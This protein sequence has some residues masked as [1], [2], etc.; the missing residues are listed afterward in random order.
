MTAPVEV[1]EC[2]S[3][4]KVPK[5][6]PVSSESEPDTSHMLAD[7]MS[8]QEAQDIVELPL[9]VKVS[10]IMYVK[11]TAH[12]VTDAAT[13][14]VQK[15]VQCQS[16]PALL[17]TWIP[18]NRESGHG[19]I[20][21]F[22]TTSP[23]HVL[24][25][26]MRLASTLRHTR[27]RMR[28]IE[29]VEAGL[30][31]LQGGRSSTSG[32][33]AA[34][35]SSEASRI[36]HEG[37]P[38]SALLDQQARDGVVLLPPRMP[39]SLEEWQRIA[40]YYVEGPQMEL[41]GEKVPFYAES[42]KMFWTPA[43]PKFSVPVSVME[44]ELFAKYESSL[45]EGIGGEEG[46]SDVL[47][48]EVSEAAS[49]VTDDFLMR[50]LSQR[51]FSLPNLSSLEPATSSEKLKVSPVGR[52]ASATELPASKEFM[53]NL[54]TDFQT[55]MKE[56]K[57]LKEQL[58]RP[59]SR[60]SVRH[61]SLPPDTMDERPESPPPPQNV[62]ETLELVLSSSRTLLAH[63][64]MSLAEKARS[65]GKKYIVYPT[66]K[67][68]KLHKKVLDAEKL[69]G[70]HKQLSQPHRKITRSVSLQRLD[71]HA[72]L[73]SA[74][75]KNRR[76]VRKASLPLTLDFPKYAEAHG[77]V[78]A[79]GER[80][81]VRGI[82]N[83]WFDEVFP[84]SR[85][86]SRVKEPEP[87]VQITNASQVELEKKVP[88]RQMRLVDSVTPV[89]LDETTA[90]IQEVEEEVRRLTELIE[91][92]RET[93][94]FH[95]SRRG[96]LY[97]KLGK[98][99]RAL[100]D[101]GRAI[102]MEPQLLDAYWQRHLIYRLQGRNAD[103]L[104]D[105][106]FILKYNKNHAD[107]YL[108]KAEICK[109]QGDSTLAIINYSQALKCQPQNGDIYYS[110]AEMYEHRSELILAMDDYAQSF[111]YN[112]ERTDAMMKHGMHHFDTS[113]WNAAI[114]DFTAL[115]KQ[116]PNDAHARTYRGRAYTKQARYV[117]A[118]KD[119]SAAIH[120]DPMNW[121]AFY[122]RGCLLRRTY[123][124]RAL[125]DF[126]TSVL[127]ND[128]FENLNSF[129][130]RAILYTEL[131]LYS[132][133][134]CDF[135]SVLELDRM[136][137]LAYLNLGLIFLLF[138]DNYFKAIQQ[139]TMALQ[140]TPTY[141]RA[142]LCRAQAYHKI[143]ELPKALKDITRAI[144]LQP[145]ALQMYI[146][147]GQYL[148]EMKKYDLAS[149][150]I[151]YAAVM[152]Q[153]TSPVQRALVQAFSND[154]SK[155]I[156]H[157]SQA[158]KVQPSPAMF[159]LLGKIQMKAKKAKDAVKSFKEALALMNPEG[160]KK[161]LTLDSAEIFYLLGLCYI[162]QVNLLKALDAFTSAIKAS[163]R[164][165]DAFYQRGLCR[166]RLNQ[167]K[168]VED[169]NRA[170]A[171]NPKLFQVYLSRAAFYGCKERFTKAILN[172][173]EAIKIEPNSVRAYLYRGA[174]K[175]YA[176]AYSQAVDDLT[177]TVQMDPTCSLAYYN[178]AICYHETK[179][180]EKALIDY[181]IV[182]LLGP[183]KEI[184][185]KV[186]INRGVLYL[187]LK[188]HANALQ[189]FK[190]AMQKSPSD[191]RI[192]LVLGLCHHRLGQFAEAVAAFDRVLQLDP[193]SVD[194]YVGRGNSYMEYGH[195]EGTKHAQ[196][197]F[198]KALHMDPKC[199]KARISLGYNLQSLGKL[200][201]AWNQFTVALDIEPKS[202][203]AFEGRAVLCLQMGDAFSALQD[204]SAALQ[205]TTTAELLTNR[206]VIHHFQGKRPDAMKDY[207][208]AIA[209]DPHYALA[210]FNA[211][212]VYLQNRQLTQARD[213][214]S[215]ALELDPSN[216]SAALNRAITN[217]LLCN[218]PEAMRDF[219]WV[220]SR[221]PSSA[222]VFFNRA[223]LY[224]TLQQHELAEKD[225]SKALSLQTNDALMYKLRADIRFRLGFKEEAL[226]DYKRA[227]HLQEIC[228]RT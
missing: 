222:A 80:E 111:S 139:F 38:I 147:R 54:Q 75:F 146:M 130:H 59:Q 116:N 112:P 40:E 57:L 97:R 123:P 150:C 51:S 8:R 223:T 21:H 202:H 46:L 33:P 145:D 184:E 89:L 26:P 220:I 127:I 69:K 6:S 177:K 47:E 189:D 191:A 195:K 84:D 85:P 16:P 203:L 162:E 58:E 22:C 94:V 140:V 207:Q 87:E 208:A 228:E 217:M 86:P 200:Q 178:R 19:T 50:I 227:V 201:R 88:A 66:K 196:K 2:V 226:L 211:A 214:Y 53:V 48:D 76:H 118:I 103:A 5:G 194:A 115:L 117:E 106:N 172:C 113:N 132:E 171:V 129:L 61:G 170:L 122:Y 179:L 81:W 24:P 18:R 221:C 131:S 101:L 44:E 136:M 34:V 52:F 17:A 28:D 175:Y 213:Y 9:E 206:G 166:M 134:V 62:E 79:D 205:L 187:E 91:E 219:E 148:F 92:Q 181:S 77:G 199:L 137:A 108:S 190:E 42:T 144:H 14:A 141:T 216:E 72:G 109:I 110:R 163:P 56:L 68:W 182:L 212:N 4:L 60:S 63:R 142:Y 32:R 185:A 83:D 143:H 224:S 49:D 161:K 12:T 104:D 90:T 107:A 204:I 198:L 124:Q 31:C 159:I 45:A 35:G 197:D 25:S 215:K 128:G 10:D 157:L 96:A 71:I 3:T 125:Q 99:T 74:T 73:R 160:A 55:S 210:Y 192:L 165:A 169:F 151:C 1:R 209:V 67:K 135:E 105:L 193:R 120:L 155:A 95:F 133:A 138:Q 164:Y 167:A 65:A 27:D 121:L 188:D 64:K 152:D 126:S 180:H 37:L 183:S 30:Q 173:N 100:E 93:S 174:L 43:P 29:Q 168:C 176:K 70:V 158:L 7:V 102:I 218:L 36:F 23:R 156:E 20:H 225:I 154:H 39:D 149:F 41:V 78:S 114:L 11:G 98:L 153:G 13:S 119:F 82:W 15:R 186:L